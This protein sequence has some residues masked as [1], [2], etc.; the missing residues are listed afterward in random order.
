MREPEELAKKRKRGGC[1]ATLHSPPFLSLGVITPP[2]RPAVQG[3]TRLTRKGQTLPP[4]ALNPHRDPKDTSPHPRPHQPHTREEEEEEKKGLRR[5]P[6][7][8]EPHLPWQRRAWRRT[9]NRSQGA[10][11]YERDAP[12]PQRQLRAHV[13]RGCAQS[14]RGQEQPC[15][16]DP[17]RSRDAVG[18]KHKPAGERKGIVRMPEGLPPSSN[19]PPFFFATLT[20]LTTDS[21]RSSAAYWAHDA[22]CATRVHSQCGRSGAASIF[23]EVFGRRTGKRRERGRASASRLPHDHKGILCPLFFV[24]ER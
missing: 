20:G 18:A 2:R 11:H 22:S 5:Q 7:S 13:P 4:P 17:L 9:L 23:R 1:S 14:E 12:R 15:S 16:L 3:H 6:G 24:E 21:L 8:P 19:F 10:H